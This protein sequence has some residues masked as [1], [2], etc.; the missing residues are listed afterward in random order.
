MSEGLIL[1]LDAANPKSYPGTGTTW[2]DLSGNG[3][4][5]TL[6]NNVGW[7]NEGN[8]CWSFTG[9]SDTISFNTSSNFIPTSGNFSIV[10]FINRN[11]SSTPLGDR[12]AVFTNTRDADGFRLQIRT[13][14][15]LHMLIGGD[16]GT[17]YVE[18]VI[19]SGY[20]V[21]DGKWHQIGVMFDRVGS[22]GTFR[23]YGI[24]D[25][26]IIGSASISSTNNP[27]TNKPA[28]I[29]L[30]NTYGCCNPYKGKLSTLSVYNRIL[31]PLE[32]NES[33][34]AMSSRYSF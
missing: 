14:G 26:R 31:T 22:L 1:H 17:S 33:Y 34:N 32:I 23:A 25:G 15:L 13:N 16:G 18:G 7:S 27:F 2:R 19:G 9:S 12:E 5:G 11:P 30:H 8:G 10:T 3:N 28:G 21:A 6:V 4:N 24:L 29:S 20:N